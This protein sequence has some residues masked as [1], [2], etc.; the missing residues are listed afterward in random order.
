[1]TAR[2]QI[3]ARCA[4]R[5]P[6]LPVTTVIDAGA[7]GDASPAAIAQQRA[8]LRAVLA[9]ADVREAVW[10][11]SPSLHAELD[12]WEA[13]PDSERGRA[14]ECA[15]VRYVARMS[16]RATPFGLFAGI[17]A[18]RVA[19]GPT[20]VTLGA[21]HRRRTRL[22]NEL[23]HR[24]TTAMARAPEVRAAVAWHANTSLVRIAGKLRYAEARL[25]EAGSGVAYHL[26]AVDP[27]PHLD[28][29]LARARDGARRDALVAALVDP[30]AEITADDAA[31]FVDELIA[32]Q[33]LVP[34]LG[35]VVT[36]PD[37]LGAVI[38]QLAIAGL[39][40]LAEAL[41][42][43]AARLVAIDDGAAAP[44]EA[45]RA[46][47]AAVEAVF[48]AVGDDTTVDPA[49]VVQV[50]LGLAV[51]ATIDRAI[52]TQVIRTV[53]ALARIARPRDDGPLARFKRDFQERWEERE[54]P[55]AEVLDEEA[56]IGFAAATGPG[57][58]GAPLLA[59]LPF[60]GATDDPQVAWGEREA[61][62]LRALTETWQRGATEL[63]LD[64]VA[65]R[66]LQAPRPAAL[67]DGWSTMVRIGARADG[68]PT[69]L[70][71]GGHG[72]S[73]ARLLGRFCHLDDELAAMTRA[74]LAAEEALTPAAIHAE[75]VH[76]AEG[77][78]GNVLCR[79][80]LRSHELVFLGMSGAPREAQ[81]TL[82]DLLVS[83]RGGRV[84]LRS[85]ALDR[86]VRPALTS[87][88]NVAG[89]GLGVYRFLAA[90]ASQD[91]HGAGWSWGPLADAPTLPR[92]RIGDVV[93]ARAQW[94]LTRDELKAL[95]AAAR[96]DRAAGF[97]AMHAL[98]SA[99]GLPR[100]I[101]L[102]DGDNELVAD[103]DHALQVDALLDALGARPRATLAEVWPALDACAVRGPAGRHA[104]EVLLT[105]AREDAP[106]AALALA[107]VDDAPRH[108]AP[109]S[110]WLYA[111]LYG[112]V[113]SA[114]RVLREAVAPVVRAAL[115]S[116]AA[117]RWFFIRY[118]D[119]QPHLRLRLTGDPAR[120]LGEVLPALQTATAPL[121]ADGSLWRVQLDTYA[122]ELERYGG[123]AGLA[124]CEEIFWR[125]SE[126]TLAVVEALD[127]DAGHDAR[128]RLALRGIDRLLGALGVDAERRRD[129]FT[130]G[131]DGLVTEHRAGAPL[132]KAIGARWRALDDELIELLALETFTD[133]H[134]L[135]PGLAA[136]VE[137]DRALAPVA[138]RLAARSDRDA[139]LDR[140]AWSLA[141]MS[142]NRMLHASQ[143]AQELVLYDLL[144]RYHERQR[145]RAAQVSA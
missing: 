40:A 27:T 58:E 100:W 130:R 96:R 26:V 98:R 123:A 3:G 68:R 22:D 71:E 54:V 116:G 89:R 111:K 134:P 80:V 65:L 101:N 141:H 92:V 52:A 109:G 132:L 16:T 24:L 133:D 126:A 21:T 14:A 95:T 29:T 37:P 108:H 10:L 112:G 119:P 46:L 79:P 128:W 117:A 73:G 91:G 7:T 97:A 20:T 63:V 11:A 28:A 60:V 94:R 135:A 66:A 75:I 78:N 62:L 142:A 84:V 44:I 118:H 107:A 1:M 33:L 42:A 140:I 31:A 69:L 110:S 50:D 81:L 56:G 48:R 45:Y 143:R 77:R 51:D 70:V 99:R 59:G 74:Q 131:R 13:A 136:L 61:W 125:D 88:H 104:S 55:L 32:A 49:R 6:R 113:S 83:V 106:R 19:P 53:E 122:P 82:D 124:L 139:L 41:R 93:V 121:V 12:A 23:L 64:E 102:A 85:R 67:P 17:G 137:R 8:W 115:A 47:A 34:A 114:D 129:V 9:R 4:V 76:L 39:D 25:G 2:W 15:L 43:I 127:G 57:S 138:A 18:G 87:A 5:A 38:D 30:A 103:L 90:L 145:A 105:F 86:E 120:L 144:R 36:G 35:V 72:P